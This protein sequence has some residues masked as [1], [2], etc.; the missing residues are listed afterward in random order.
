MSDVTC[1]ICGEPWDYYGLKHGDL[2]PEEAERFLHGQGCPT[3]GYGTR[4]TACYG[5][6]RTPERYSRATCPDCYGKRFVFVRRCL[7]APEPFYRQWFMGYQPTAKHG[8]APWDY[9][10]I[11]RDPSR[12]GPVESGRAYCPTCWAT[13]P[14]CEV[15]GG[16]GQYHPPAAEEVAARH[17]AHLESH[18]NST[19]EDIIAYL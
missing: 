17:L 2:R 8:P 1:A 9:T 11:E 12:D 19:D 5:T 13:A 4:C 10:Q 15:C 3:C 7:G 6:G 18:A 16:D 14:L